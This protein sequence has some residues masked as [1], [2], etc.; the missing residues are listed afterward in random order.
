M[1]SINKIL[2]NISKDKKKSLNESTNELDKTQFNEIGFLRK[3]IN[4]TSQ[5]DTENFITK[6]NPSINHFKKVFYRFYN[7]SI[8]SF[9][10]YPKGKNILD[11][12]VETTQ[13]FTFK[14]VG[15]LL[16]RMYL[17]LKL[18]KIITDDEV[19]L[20]YIKNVGLGIIKNIDFKIKGETISSINGQKLYLLQKLN[21][22]SGSSFQVKNNVVNVPEENL[23]YKHETT[24]TFTSRGPATSLTLTTLN[25]LY[26]RPIDT[27]TEQLIIPL[28]FGFSK[29][30]SL[31]LPLFLF[32]TEDIR[33][34]IT[35]RALN[36]LYTVEQFEKDYWYYVKN[37]DVSGYSLPTESIQFRKDALENTD[38]G[39]ILNSNTNTFGE[40]TTYRNAG[41][42]SPYYLKRY[43]SRK[44]GIPDISIPAQNIKY[45]LYSCCNSSD[46][47]SSGNYYI[48][49]VI[50]T[51]QIFVDKDLRAKFNDMFIYS[52]LFQHCI[53][54]TRLKNNTYT[55]TNEIHVNIKSPI[56][57]LMLAI[58]RNDNSLRNEWLNFTNYEDSDMTEEKILKYQ[59]NWWYV[60]N[61]EPT[62][63][64]NETVGLYN[65]GSTTTIYSLTP[66]N[67]QEFM[68]RYGPYGE[69]GQIQDTSGS[70]FSNWPESIKGNESLYTIEEIDEFRKTWKYRSASDIPQINLSNFNSTWKE[71]PLNEME[72]RFHTHIKEDVKPSVYYNTLQ[73]LLYSNNK[74][75]PGVYMYS[76]NIDPHSIQPHG[77]FKLNPTLLFKLNVVVSEIQTFN[78]ENNY[79]VITPYAICYNIIN[80]KQDTFSLL[81][82]NS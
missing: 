30:P 78:S 63:P 25:K 7:F 82:Y 65:N 60:S 34:E 9:K 75:D 13:T 54:D 48:S 59:D 72:I 79:L 6:G 69:A 3:M 50:E 42:G 80:I 61:S 2:S 36:E 33:I 39:D 17:I 58:Q 56:K 18:P 5:Q 51:E 15:D 35:F 68:F 74:L 37:H 29:E 26:N 40:Q 28:L 55:G 20:K 49:S 43:E 23:K 66:D 24:T 16:G 76:F 47:D 32:K 4:N 57:Q 41:N 10:N 12:N 27:D 11:F 46:T 38:M 44:T 22:D 1:N 14:N 53:E 64:I 8:Q 71:S 62:V 52:Y 67:F 19:N 21:Y 81:Y 77:S 31:Y 45:H 73:S 70:G